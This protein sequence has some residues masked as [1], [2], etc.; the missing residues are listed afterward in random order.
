MFFGSATV[1]FSESPTGHRLPFALLLA[2][3]TIVA[4]LFA[5]SPADATRSLVACTTG[6]CCVPGGRSTY[7]AL[8][9]ESA[10]ASAIPA[11]PR[12]SPG[13]LLAKGFITMKPKR[14]PIADEEAPGTGGR[15]AMHRL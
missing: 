15:G 14:S 12:G 1:A 2:S 13:K 5:L 3:A 6:R 11:S 9:D 8:Y 4:F 7:E 10:M